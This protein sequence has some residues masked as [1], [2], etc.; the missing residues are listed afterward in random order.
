MTLSGTALKSGG[1]PAYTFASS[2]ELTF[3]LNET[4][5]EP[6]EIKIF[7]PNGQANFVEREVTLV[8]FGGSYDPL[9]GV[10]INL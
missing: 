1:T 4:T 10:Y 6:G 7:V 5:F 2:R 3:Y 8:E 9:N